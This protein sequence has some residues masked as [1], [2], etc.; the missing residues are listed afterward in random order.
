MKLY[1]DNRKLI[2]YVSKACYLQEV[3]HL[4]LTEVVFIYSF[5][6]NPLNGP[7]W[8]SLSE[9]YLQEFQ[10]ILVGLCMISWNPHTELIGKAV[11][12]IRVRVP[13]NPPSGKILEA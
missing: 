2:K 12:P 9:Y 7:N 10:F 13:F 6:R 11:M 4:T 8:M 5:F 3:W 1:E